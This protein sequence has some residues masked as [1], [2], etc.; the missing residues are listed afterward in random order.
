MRPLEALQSLTGMAGPFRFGAMKQ[1]IGAIEVR[2]VD[3]ERRIIEGIANTRDVDSYGTIVEPK[4]ARYKLPIPLLWQHDR[5]EPVGEVTVA[6]VSDT[7]IR[8]TAQIRKI[9]EDGPFKTITDKAWQ[10]VK[11]RLVRG[12]SVGFMPVKTAGGTSPKD[13]LRFVEWKWKELSL[14]T[15]P[16]NEGATISAVRAAFAVSGDSHPGLTGHDPSHS[17]NRK[18]TIAEQIQ[19]LENTRAAQ[20][21]RQNAIAEAAQTRGETMTVTEGDEFDSI[22]SSLEGIDADLVR[23]RSL[24]E[25]TRAAA[26]PVNGTST[27]AASQTRA[28]EATNQRGTSV[29]RVQARD[30]A[31][32]GFARYCMSLAAC[33]GNRNEAA[34]YARRTWSGDQGEGVAALMVR[35]PVAAGDTTTSGWASQLVQTNYLSEFLELL[36]PLTLIG[37]VPGF[38]RVPFHTQVVLQTGGGTYAWVGQGV[39]KPVTKPTVSSVNLGIAKAAGIIVITDELAR[40]SQPSAQEL[41]RRELLGGM[42]QYLDNQLI[43]ANVAAVPNVSPASLTNGVTGDSPSGTA[44][45]NARADLIEL[46][47][48]MLAAGYPRSELVFLMS[49]SVEFVLKSGVNSGGNVNLPEF[50]G[51]RLFGIPVVS[52][53]VSGLS[54]QI[55]LLHAPSIAFADDGGT[56]ISISREASVIMDSAPQN[57][58]VQDGYPPVHTSLWQNNLVAIRAERWINWAKARSTAVHR[59]HTVAYV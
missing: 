8:V 54:A 39:P 6:K 23:L 22:D 17:G 44:A 56:E 1:L 48:D 58:D 11:H 14:V 4:G 38:T 26:T 36:R 55:V 2:A 18:M 29:V 27:T 9:E 43:D 5:D 19:A 10:A 34:E 47:G 12:F 31:G 15:L 59:I 28:G 35:A 51:D 33:N 24:Q 53:N 13:P 20:V 40:S 49:E 16:A 46:I 7:E 45:S 41:V 25:R 50:V 57:V 37:R 3:E 32:L 42:Q 30:E 21:A 52:A